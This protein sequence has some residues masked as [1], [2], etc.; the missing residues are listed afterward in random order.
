MCAVASY[1][2][3][4]AACEGQMGAAGRRLQHVSCVPTHALPAHVNA[5]CTY[6]QVAI[7]CNHQRAVGKAHDSQMEKLETRLAEFRE[8]V[9]VGRGPQHAPPCFR[10]TCS[11]ILKGDRSA[12]PCFQCQNQLVLHR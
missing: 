11:D 2:C 9:N 5:H 4:N 8:Q 7:L 12:L 3:T 6:A 10:I 1:Q